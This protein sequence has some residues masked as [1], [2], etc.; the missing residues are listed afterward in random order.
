VEVVSGTRV[1]WV[2]KESVE[3]KR[4]LKKVATK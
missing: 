1:T 2:L 3:L 4:Q